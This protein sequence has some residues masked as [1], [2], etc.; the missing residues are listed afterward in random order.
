MDFRFTYETYQDVRDNLFKYSTPFLVVAGFF[1]YLRI[2]PATHQQKVIALIEYV[3]N[4]EPWKGLLGASIGIVVF[5]S[6][7]FVLTE[8][9]QVHDQWYDKYVIR[10][11]Y[12]Y[13]VDFI[14]P[15]LVRPF[16]SAFTVRFGEV[17]E[18]NLRDFQERLYYHFVRDRDTKIPKNTLVRFYEVIT[19]Y[20]LTQINEIVLI[21]LISLVA[22]YRFF[23][24]PETG[25]R[26]RLLTNLLLLVIAFLVN[27]LW[28]RRSLNKV[29]RATEDEIRAI[30]EDDNL[31]Q[32]L[33]ARLTSVSDDYQIPRD[34][35]LLKLIP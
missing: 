33:K 29:R 9:F 5:V 31:R 12:Y 18:Q 32:E 8:L 21:L 3:T 34:D 24:P 15:K 30:H 16:A 11:R 35:G 2:L 19:V 1:T 14:L 22:F 13:A 27:R 23:G 20:W 26:T 28:V 25:Y 17:A 4:T 7:A 6:L 10:W